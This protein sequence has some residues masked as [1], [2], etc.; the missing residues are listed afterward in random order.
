MRV[1]R[2]SGGT[3]GRIGSSSLAASTARCGA[4][5]LSLETRPG[6]TASST[7]RPSS[8]VARRPKPIHPGSGCF[9]CGSSGWL[10]LPLES[11]C[12]ISSIASFTGAP[13][14]SS[15]RKVIHTRS[16]LAC[17]PATQLTQCS[18]VVSSIRKYGPTVCDGVGARVAS[19]FKRCGLRPAQHDVE[20]E[21][22]CP[23][24]LRRLQI[25]FRDHPLSRSFVRYGLEDGITVKQRIAGKIHLRHQTRDKS[26]PE[27]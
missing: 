13:S 15:T 4:C 19:G 5:N 24:R 1:S 14:P 12:Q 9:G 21:T 20:L 27:D 26:H 3:S 25:E 6:F 2:R 16:P 23:L 10:Y 7:H 8:P 22:L 11:A 17:G 18:S